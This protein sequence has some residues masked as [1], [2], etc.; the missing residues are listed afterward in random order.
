[1]YENRRVKFRERRSE[2]LWRQL[3]Q[4]CKHLERKNLENAVGKP[5]VGGG[6]YSLIW[7]IRGR[8]AGEGMVLWPRCPKQGIQFDL[9]LS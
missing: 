6:G 9:P 5:V 1:M 7:A 4:R 8:A 3:G 2:Q